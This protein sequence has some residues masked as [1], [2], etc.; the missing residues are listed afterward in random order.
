M[1]DR[2]KNAQNKGADFEAHTEMLLQ[3]VEKSMKLDRMKELEK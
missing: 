1:K 3:K 2:Y